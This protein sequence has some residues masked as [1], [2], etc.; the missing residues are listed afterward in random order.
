M[1]ALY[2]TKYQPDGK[3]FKDISFR[4]YHFGECHTSNNS[5]QEKQLEPNISHDWNRQAVFIKGKKP[6]WAYLAQIQLKERQMLF[7]ND[8][9]PGI[10][11]VDIEVKSGHIGIAATSI[12][13]TKLLSN[14]IHLTP[15]H[16][17][18]AVSI[19][20][21]NINQFNEF[22]IRNTDIDSKYKNMELTLHS[23][24][25]T[26][27]QARDKS[28]S[29]QH[30]TSTSLPINIGLHILDAAQNWPKPV[31]EAPHNEESDL[32]LPIVE[33]KDIATHITSKNKPTLPTP[34]Y[35]K[36][37]RN[38]KM[39][40]DDA[41][42]LTYLYQLHNPK[43]HFEFGTWHGF[44]AKL[45]AKSSDTEVWTLNLTDGETTRD[46]DAVYV[47]TSKG[48]QKNSDAGSEIGKLFRGTK[49]EDRIHQLYG[50]SLEWNFDTFSDGFFDSVLI[51]GGHSKQVV[52]NDSTNAIR[53]L[54][55][56]GICLWHDFCCDPNII[57]TSIPTRGVFEAIIENFDFIS[58]YFSKLFWIRPSYI[59]VGLRNE[60]LF[61][62]N[63]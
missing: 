33:I 14:E 36:Q 54:R 41:P 4:F 13:P 30:K 62:K 3:P 32:T 24:D 42:I 61:E 27:A 37:Y 44:G 12:N 1:N 46:G 47:N 23:F 58:T 52:K 51:D 20:I 48:P 60:K 5:A 6:L 25:F 2:F 53:L 56:G 19:E 9:K 57:L 35:K 16:G 26:L 28:S 55:T 11:T 21:D 18:I 29:F 63:P 38:W 7:Q 39:E 15:E 50:D 17:R 10:L 59:L 40:I 49:Y 22:F 8:N 43:K 45:V 34:N 31:D